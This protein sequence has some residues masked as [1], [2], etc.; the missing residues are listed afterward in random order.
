M[1]KLSLIIIS[2]ILVTL[3]VWLI[4]PEYGSGY[5]EEQRRFWNERRGLYPA[6]CLPGHDLNDEQMPFASPSCMSM[7]F[8]LY[9][10]ATAQSMN[11]GR[12]SY[13]SKMS[14]GKEQHRRQ[15]LLRNTEALDCDMVVNPP[16]DRE[17]IPLEGRSCFA[18]RKLAEQG[19]AE[20]C[21]QMLVQGKNAS[22]IRS[23]DGLEKAPWGLVSNINHYLSLASNNDSITGEFLFRYFQTIQNEF[24]NSFSTERI[25]FNAPVS[26]PPP[27]ESVEGFE[28]FRHMLVTGDYTGLAVLKLLNQNH[29]CTAIRNEMYLTLLPLAQAGDTDAQRKIAQLV[30]T[31]DLFP[32]WEIHVEMSKQLE[33][34]SKFFPAY[35]EWLKNKNLQFKNALVKLGI[36]SP[37]GTR[38]WQIHNAA[39]NFAYEAARKGDLTCMALWLQFGIIDKNYFSRE[40]WENIFIFTRCLL[41]A[42]YQPFLDFL[43]NHNQ[44]GNPLLYH[45]ICDY[46]SPASCEKL[47]WKCADIIAKQETDNPSFIGRLQ[48]KAINCNYELKEVIHDMGETARNADAAGLQQMEDWCNTCLQEGNLP[49]LCA[50][51]RI[52]D[53]GIGVPSNPGKAYILLKRALEVSYQ[54]PLWDVF[55]TDGFTIDRGQCDSTI[56]YISAVKLLLVHLTIDHP[57]FPGRN[58]QEAF[59][60]ASNMPREVTDG[61]AG[62][63]FNYALGRLHEQGIGTSKD[64]KKALECY[65]KSASGP[66]S[67]S[68]CEERYEALGK[69]IGIQ[70]EDP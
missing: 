14:E 49:A 18:R 56:P 28:E 3:G 9:M 61:I 63:R 8:M 39:S 38:E 53:K 36:V 22:V 46:Y 54:C 50:F 2:I 48:D 42:G 44:H 15:I 31:L 5:S 45:I 10:L 32:N 37:Y 68:G 70:L 21:L 64:L 57:D 6:I 58:E 24:K 40:E 11:E 43:G 30:L 16:S 33:R 52:Y 34:W 12:D 7:Q 1:K 23:K 55:I 59:Q 67:H 19:N 29:T 51:A 26:D 66:F 25:R 65:K 17:D 47:F 69:Q 60:M 35:P 4:S 20:A 27:P 13:L 41:D 62:G